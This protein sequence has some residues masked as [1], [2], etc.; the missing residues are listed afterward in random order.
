MEDCSKQRNKKKSKTWYIDLY[1][2]RRAIKSR[3]NLCQFSHLKFRHVLQAS[4][5][6][7]LT[8]TLREAFPEGYS[9]H[10]C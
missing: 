6:D 7:I 8:N 2:S 4:Y 10:L 1:K 9:N 3:V 5:L